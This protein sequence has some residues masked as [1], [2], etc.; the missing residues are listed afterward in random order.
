MISEHPFSQQQQLKTDR[1]DENSRETR[2]ASQKTHLNPDV[3]TLSKRG[4]SVEPML[5]ES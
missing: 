2:Y 3:V 1:V 4:S 5:I